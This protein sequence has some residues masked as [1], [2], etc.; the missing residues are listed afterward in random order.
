MGPPLMLMAVMSPRLPLAWGYPC[1]P[2]CPADPPFPTGPLF[3]AQRPLLL[4]PGERG[5]EGPCGEERGC[6]AQPHFHGLL[7]QRI[8]IP[9]QG[10]AHGTCSLE[11]CPRDPTA[12]A[13]LHRA[14][15]PNPWGEGSAGAPAPLHPASHRADPVGTGVGGPTETP[16]RAVVW[17]SH[18]PPLFTGG[19]GRDT[20]P[21]VQHPHIPGGCHSP[22][23]Q[24]YPAVSPHNHCQD[25]CGPIG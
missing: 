9:E 10:C 12:W 15:P 19:E 18:L 24:W 5:G 13:Q 11:G 25:P 22:G 1:A 7:Q 14:P 23:L 8:P 4:L 6:A 3:P 20:Q 17:S 2:A 21:Q 16:I